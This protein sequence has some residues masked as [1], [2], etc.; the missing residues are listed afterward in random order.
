MIGHLT[1]PVPC[2]ER[3]LLI[4]FITVEGGEGRR[5]IK[6]SLLLLIVQLA[7]VSI[8]T[9]RSLENLINF[10]VWRMLDCQAVR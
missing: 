10:E 4:P 1:V 8:Q 5:E 3:P 7:P 9:A 6:S 2:M